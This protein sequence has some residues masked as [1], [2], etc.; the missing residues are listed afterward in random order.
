MPSQFWEAHIGG[1]PQPVAGSALLSST[2]LTDVS[3]APQITI[4]ANFLNYYG[5]TIRL[6]SFGFFSNTLTP[7]LLLGFYYGGVAGVTLG[8]SGAVTT[9]TGATSWPWRLEM[10]CT[11]RTT[12]STGTIMCQG[13][14]D[15]GTSLTA[16]TR[17]PIPNTSLAV[18]TIDTTSAKAITTGAQWGANSASN[19]LTCHQML[20]ESLA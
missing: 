18:V 20:A 13:F 12:G 10:T 9:T 14:L 15:L 17:I 7:T 1:P 4:P 3:P 11:V 19:T 2:T 16:V 8:N 5:A 6:T